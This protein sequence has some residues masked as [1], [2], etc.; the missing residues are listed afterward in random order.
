[1]KYFVQTLILVGVVIVFT[2]CQSVFSPEIENLLVKMRAKMDPQDKLSSMTSKIVDGKFR[3]N[4]KEKGS[5]I[6]IK[7]QNPHMLRFDIIIPGEVSIVKA[8]DGKTA[9]A[10]STK[11]GYKVLT[12]QVFNAM[13]FQAAFMN[14]S[15]RAEDIFKNIKFDGEAKVMGQMCYKLICEPKKEY[16]SQRIV[17]FVDKKS[18]LLRKRIET[19]GSPEK[20]T[21]TVSTIMLDYKSYDGILVPQVL[22][23]KVNDKLMEFEVTSVKWNEKIHISAFDP[24]EQ[25][26]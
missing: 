9:W 23:S 26:K 22:I 15:I 10:Y 3:R 8:Y 5:T 21:F 19:Q 16:N 24:P 2:G 20:G 6:S 14:P 4:S 13:K 17:M 12:G 25:M 11:T 7:V 1:M 18:Y